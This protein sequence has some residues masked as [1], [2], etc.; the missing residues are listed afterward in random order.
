MDQAKIKQSDVEQAPEVG[1]L[2]F[3]SIIASAVHD[4][5][6]SL[7]ML[8]YSVDEIRTTCGPSSCESAS[9]FSQLRYEGQRVNNHLIQ[10]LAIYRIDHANY[11]P[12]IEEHNVEEFLLESAAVHESLLTPKGISVNANCDP[13][14]MGF[15]DRE[16]VSGVV[17]NVVN[18][19]YRYSKDKISLLAESD[20]EGRLIIHIDDNGNGYPKQMLCNTTNT[21]THINFGTGSTGLGL[22]FSAMVAAA[23]K[24]KKQCGFIRCSN[25]GIDGGGRFSICLP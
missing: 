24:N 7:S 11:K 15:F 23:H 12:N 17:N 19:A 1:V 3:S 25:E 5:K 16:L 22:Y 21:S 8:L 20:P 10:L 4:M 6:N 14:L 13:N 9:K 2:D 18:N